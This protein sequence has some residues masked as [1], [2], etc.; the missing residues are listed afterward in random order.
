MAATKFT[1]IYTIKSNGQVCTK[2]LEEECTYKMAEKFAKM[3]LNKEDTTLI[4]VVES[5]KLYPNENKKNKK[6]I[7][8]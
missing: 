8:I 4:C 6:E 5:W 1:A 7:K 3:I 2:T